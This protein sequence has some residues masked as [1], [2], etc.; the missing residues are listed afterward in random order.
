M[1]V[2]RAQATII[3]PQQGEP[4]APIPHPRASLRLGV[5]PARDSLRRCAQPDGPGDLLR[6]QHEPGRDRCV[7]GQHRRQACA[8]D[9]VEHLGG[10]W[11]PGQLRQERG[12]L[13]LPDGA[14]P[15]PSG[16]GHH[17]VHLVAAHRPRQP[18]RGRLRALQEHHQGQAQPVH[19]VL[20]QGRQGLRQAGHRALRP[21]DEWRLVPVVP[22][23]LRQQP[24]ALHQGLAAHRQAVPRGGRQEREVPVESRISGARAAT[25]SSILATR[26]WITSA[27]PA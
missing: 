26:T 13:R 5:R 10:S 20:G 12:H 23:Q 8:V 27:S 19:P 14:G 11:R 6:E 17:A 18:R 25:P 21:R 9:P 3:A 15:R 2:A 24:Q 4:S 22:G 7:P 16:Q 1:A